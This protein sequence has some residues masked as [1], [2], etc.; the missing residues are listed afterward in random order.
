MG[1]ELFI[2]KEGKDYDDNQRNNERDIQICKLDLHRIAQIG[3]FFP[4]RL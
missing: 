2:E 3:E 4:L 1:V